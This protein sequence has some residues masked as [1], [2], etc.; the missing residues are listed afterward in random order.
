MLLKSAGGEMQTF[1]PY[2]VWIDSARALD[3]KRRR[4]QRNEGLIILRTLL[5]LYPKT[6]TGRP[7]GWPYHPATKMWA[8]SEKYL[9][10]YI[11]AVCDACEDIIDGEDTVR[12]QVEDIVVEYKLGNAVPPWLGDPRL[13]L[14]HRSN[15]LRKDPDYYRQMWPDL[16]ADLPYYWPVS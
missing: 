15:L 10:E 3:P 16:A 4:N 1:L 12:P 9:V 11:L 7:G 14:S 8:G 13:H 2:T 6:K 5:G